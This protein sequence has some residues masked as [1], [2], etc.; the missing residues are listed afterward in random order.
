[1]NTV[2][3][4]DYDQKMRDKLVECNE[5][6]SGRDVAVANL[7]EAKLAYENAQAQ[8]AE[9][10]D[11]NIDLVVQYRDDLKRRLGIVDDIIAYVDEE[12]ITEVHDEQVAEK[13]VCDE[14]ATDE[15]VEQPIV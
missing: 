2:E 9:Y 4:I 7:A 13:C 6:L 5:W 8:V 10:T 11:E 14:I 3:I 1:M 12:E 15:I